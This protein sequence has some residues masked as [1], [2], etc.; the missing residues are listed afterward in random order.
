MSKPKTIIKVMVSSVQEVTDHVVNHYGDGVDYQYVGIGV[1]ADMQE[2]FDVT[3]AVTKECLDK[4]PD[5][6]DPDCPC[7]DLLDP[8]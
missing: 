4:F 1:T 8:N 3:K 5:L 2:I 6:L 7:P